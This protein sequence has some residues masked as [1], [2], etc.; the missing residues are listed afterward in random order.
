[1]QISALVTT[2]EARNDV[3]GQLRSVVHPLAV[4]PERWKHHPPNGFLSYHLAGTVSSSQGRLMVQQIIRK[5]RS[6]NLLI[7]R[8]LVSSLI[9]SASHDCGWHNS[10]LQGCHQWTNCLWL[11]K[12]TTSSLLL[13]N[14]SASASRGLLLFLAAQ[15]HKMFVA[16]PFRSDE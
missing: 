6:S 8:S 7:F 5:T 3:M 9:E 14:H 11:T 10:Y 13:C 2:S 4:Y 12:V 15:Q 1:M 16:S